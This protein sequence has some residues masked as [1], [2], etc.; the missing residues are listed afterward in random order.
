MSEMT[1]TDELLAY[2]DRLIAADKSGFHCQREI[3]EVIAELRKELAISATKPITV[4]D[5]VPEH[6][7]KY[8]NGSKGW[9]NTSTECPRTWFSDGVSTVQL[10][11]ALSERKGVTEYV[12]DAHDSHANLT[13]DNGNEGCIIPIEGPARI[14]VNRD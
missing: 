12:V 6:V 13:I 14:I 2:F 8:G 9:I 7:K 11:E 10:H 3:T 1:R 5:Y 4:G